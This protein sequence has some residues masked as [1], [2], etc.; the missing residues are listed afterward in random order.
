MLMAIESGNPHAGNPF[1]TDVSLPVLAAR[2]AGVLVVAAALV[3]ASPV[4]EWISVAVLLWV[5]VAGWGNHVL[6][7]ENL[8]CLPRLKTEVTKA[9]ALPAVTLIVPVRDEEVGIE[10][11]ARA[12]A[13]IDYPG[14]E[15]LIVDDHSSDSTPEILARLAR[16]LPRLRVLQAPEL[17][18]GWTGKVSASMYGF[19]QS[20]PESRWLM[21]T[22][23]RVVFHRNAVLSAIAHAEA[24]GLD[25]LSG[26]LRFEGK[27]LPEELITMIQNRGLVITARGFGGGPP[28]AAFGHGS[29]TV[30]RREVYARIGGHASHP[31]HPLED[32]MLANVARDSGAAT[33][34]VIASDIVSI[35]RYHG[36][37][38]L[39]ERM[40]RAFR[41]AASD[42]L[43][44][45]IDR[46]TLEFCLNVLPF[47]TLVG[48]LLGMAL[49]RFQ[50]ALF[51]MSAVALLAYLAGS[52]TPRDCRGICGF[53]PWVAWLYPFGSALWI[54]LLLLTMSDRLRGRAVYWRGRKIYDAKRD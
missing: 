23:A 35:R 14:L 25:F 8:K 21:F 9:D 49:G 4:L 22:D 44:N 27:N 47:V 32:F 50:P 48:S 34:A 7:A 51:V 45:L 31:A 19:R 29:F 28:R 41:N 17:P 3:S 30:I 53:R 16:E 38:D 33:A 42:R 18:A 15:I 10:P 26:V 43:V 37:P 20:N 46:T 2:L 1:D 40:A 24:N 39:R 54:V 11:A 36:F 52:C 12:L 13:A 6:F 5:L